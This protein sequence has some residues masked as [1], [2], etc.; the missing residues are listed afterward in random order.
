M[1]DLVT[2]VSPRWFHGIQQAY[3]ATTDLPVNVPVGNQVSYIGSYIDYNT[4]TIYGDQYTID[5][6]TPQKIAHY[7][8]IDGIY[9]EVPYFD[10]DGSITHSSYFTFNPTDGMALYKNALFDGI[11]NVNKRITFASYSSTVFPEGSLWRNR[12]LNYR[13]G[14]STIFAGGPIYIQYVP[15]TIANTTAETSTITSGIGETALRAGTVLTGRALRLR[16]CG[17]ISTQGSPTATLRIKLGS[18]TLVSSTGTLPP[19]LVNAGY[20]LVFDMVITGTGAS[21]TIIG[22]GTSTVVSGSFVSSPARQLTMLTPATFNGTIPNTFDLTYQWGTADPN[23]SLT[24]TNSTLEI[25][26]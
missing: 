14:D 6:S 26:G 23:N 18:T 13:V 16:S 3:S 1:A 25:L 5:I 2:S 22:Q 9:S 12:T 15:R 4:T 17:F 21:A 8:V 10:L 11:V 7:R 19:N 20:I 24:V